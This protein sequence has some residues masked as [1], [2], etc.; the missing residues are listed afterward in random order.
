[1]AV[2]SE[3]P[4]KKMMSE[5]KTPELSR[6]SIEIVWHFGSK[7]L[8]G[9]CC[10]NLSLWEILALDRVAETTRLPGAGG[11][12]DAWIHQE[13]GGE[14]REPTGKERICNGN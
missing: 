6:A 14:S 1:M 9:Q 4:K 13:W 3:V 7:G 5:T 12:A 11:G 8:D 2:C 10:E